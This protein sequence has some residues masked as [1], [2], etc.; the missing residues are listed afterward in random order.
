[1][2]ETWLSAHSDEAKTVELSLCGFDVKS[3]PRQS[4]ARGGG[5]ATIYKSI[6][7]SNVPFNFFLL[8]SHIVRNSVGFNYSTAHHT[9]FFMFVPPTT[10]PTKQSN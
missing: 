4:R 9:T 8:Y 5:I 3:F 1:M 6:L 7:G 10:K 2:T